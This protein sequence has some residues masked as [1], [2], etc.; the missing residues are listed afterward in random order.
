M[1]PPLIL[2]SSMKSARSCPAF[3]S[4]SHFAVNI[5]AADQMDLSNHFARQQEDKFAG[6]EWEEGIGGVPLFPDCAGRF[7]CETY[8]KLD[9]GDHW[10]FVGRVLAFD[11]F[12]R[13]PLCFH[14]GSYAMV[15][16]H[17]ETFPKA[18]QG[19]PEGAEQG[20]M[21]NH[22]FFLMLRAVRAYQE[23]YQPKLG[24]LGL[25]L[26][27]AR[28]LLVLNDLSDLSA[29]DLVVHLHAP[30][31]EARVALSNLEDR[32]LVTCASGGCSLTEAGQAKA[33]QCWRLAEAHAQETF[34]DFSDTEMEAFTG[35]LR[36]LIGS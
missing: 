6:V 7:Q 32:G 33:E 11:D 30:L 23:K 17:P 16:S 26:I 28:S 3:E 35:V 31:D 22:T 25:S 27:E 20:R 21:G 14:Q 18:N 8:D 9:G 4:A 29:E 10:I 5:L 34:K 12:G 2:W 13:S 36:K 24:A 1:D 15:F 19:M